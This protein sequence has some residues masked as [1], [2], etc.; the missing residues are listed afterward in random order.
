MRGRGVQEFQIGLGSGPRALLV[1]DLVD[2]GHRWF[3]QDGQ[4]RHHDVE[5]VR[6][7]FFKRQE[8]FVFPGQQHVAHTAFH[9]G[10]GGAAC[11]RVQHR[12]VL[13]QITDVGARLVFAAAVLFQRVGPR[14][15]VVPARAARG[16]RV[17]GD[18]LHAV[19]DQ[20]VPVLDAFGVALAHQEHDGR[21]IGRAVLR[22][23]RLPVLGNQAAVGDGVNVIGQRQ[24]HHIGF[25]PIDDRARLAARTAVRL[26]DGQVHI[27]LVLVLLDEGVIDG[28]IELA[29][30][31]VRHVQQRLLLLCLSRRHGRQRNRHHR[32]RGQPIRFPERHSLLPVFG[33]MEASVR[34][35]HPER[36]ESLFDCSSL[37]GI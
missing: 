32:Q 17:G 9:E 27:G 18:D 16:L 30:G 2:H 1:H 13:E 35:G 6:T 26:T 14:G 10:G 8:G 33:N 22:Q 4:R 3:S 19:L 31:V 11:A 29:R 34:V 24:R 25:Q 20:V 23:T 36:N 37:A 21:G 5:L 28:A 15:Q 7:Q 12:Y